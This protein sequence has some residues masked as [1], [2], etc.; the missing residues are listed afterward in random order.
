MSDQ[1]YQIKSEKETWRDEVIEPVMLVVS[2]TILELKSISSR[3]SIAVF[4]QFWK[5]FGQY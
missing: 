4:W 5:I 3:K 1:S 2:S